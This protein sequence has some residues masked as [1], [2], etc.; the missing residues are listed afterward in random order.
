MCV[1][2]IYTPTQIKRTFIKGQRNDQA[3]RTI[4]NRLFFQLG[5][6]RQIDK[7]HY[8]HQALYETMRIFIYRCMGFSRK[9]YLIMA[10]LVTVN[11][12]D[13]AE[14]ASKV[15]DMDTREKSPTVEEITSCHMLIQKMMA[16][17]AFKYYGPD[18]GG[19][20]ATLPLNP[21]Q[22]FPTLA[23]N[24]PAAVNNI[25]SYEAF[26]QQGVNHSPC[27]R[28]ITLVRNN[29]QRFILQIW[30]SIHEPLIASIWSRF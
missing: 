4:S 20:D 5:C 29:A 27:H 15:C 30:K 1:R 24:S 19:T 28:F 21:L 7:P 10:T 22:V 8:Y 23:V 9:G 6:P 26:I 2:F 16:E 17:H 11:I 14:L 12:E 13:L 3:I 18:E 25:E